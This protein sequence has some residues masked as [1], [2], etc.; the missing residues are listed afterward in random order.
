MII[1]GHAAMRKTNDLRINN[2]N[3]PVWSADHLS[4]RSDCARVHA[5]KAEGSGL[6]HLGYMIIPRNNLWESAATNRR[7]ERSLTTEF[8]FLFRQPNKKSSKSDRYI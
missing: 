8:D 5:G 1:V 3:T 2:T 6:W 4:S 7:N